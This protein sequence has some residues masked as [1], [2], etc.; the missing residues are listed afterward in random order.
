MKPIRVDVSP[1][2]PFF[3]ANYVAAIIETAEH[4]EL[5][6]SALLKTAGIQRATLYARDAEVS[7]MQ[8]VRLL[9]AIDARA[10]DGFGLQNGQRSRFEDF[11]MLGYAMY[12]SATLG[13]AI[14]RHIRYQ[15]LL[16]PFVETQLVLDG[17]KAQLVSPLV[18]PEL[19][20]N[21][22]V[23]RYCLEDHF[24]AW[25]VISISFQEEPHW[26]DEV[27][28]ALPAPRNTALYGDFFQCPVS[29]GQP[30]NK[31]IF[32]RELLDA[33]F[34]FANQREARIAEE[35]CQSMLADILHQDGILGDIHQ[36]L[37]RAPGHFPQIG[38]VAARLRMSERTLRRRA[39]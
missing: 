28:F 36:L 4:F 13:R 17:D 37:S 21:P 39:G 15:P 24:A 26:F 20:E 25:Q 12:A 9:D 2:D 33:P 23:A 27:Q 11:G 30:Q 34:V 10:I 16:R 31:C 8:C 14:D 22:G 38:E 19:A 29:F 35:R 1:E 3:P 7:L 6:S 32:N 5:D 18:Y